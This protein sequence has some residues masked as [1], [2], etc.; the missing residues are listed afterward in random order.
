VDEVL[1]EQPI[2]QWVLSVPYPL[3]FL[4]ASGPSVMGEVLGIVYRCIATH[5]I[6]KER[7]RIS[8]WRQGTAFS[9]TREL[10]ALTH[11]LC[12]LY[13]FASFSYANPLYNLISVSDLHFYCLVAGVVGL[14][15]LGLRRL[16]GPNGN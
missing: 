14:I 13:S 8:G 16:V 10:S 15:G 7:D 3:R 4:F 6:K 5:L 9:I 12:F 1:P 2:R 11:H